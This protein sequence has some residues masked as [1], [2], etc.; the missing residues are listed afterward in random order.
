MVLQ[1]KMPQK[2]RPTLRYCEDGLGSARCCCG[3]GVLFGGHVW[4]GWMCTAV[5]NRQDRLTLEVGLCLCLD[6]SCTQLKEPHGLGPVACPAL[7][8]TYG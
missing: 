2:S 1:Q 5:Q 3:V 7:K 4:G 6:L 8:A